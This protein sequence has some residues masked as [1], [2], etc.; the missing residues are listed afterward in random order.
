MSWRGELAKIPGLVP[1]VQLVKQSAAR[2]EEIV[3]PPPIV[4][5]AELTTNP[6]PGNP[7]RPTEPE[8]SARLPLTPDQYDRLEQTALEDQS[9]PALMA[10]RPATFQL[11]G[12][13]AHISSMRE[14]QRYVDHNFEP[15]LPA[16]FQAGATFPPI[17]YVNRFTQDESDLLNAV[18]EQVSI[19]TRQQFGRGIRPIGNLL[20]QT[21][22][23]RVMHHLAHT[24]AQPRLSVFE[25]GPG[26]GYLG[27]MLASTGHQYMSYDVTQA[28]YLWQSFL[29]DALAGDEFVELATAPGAEAAR[30]AHMPWWQYSKL[31]HNCP[32]RA[33]VVYSNSNLGEMTDLA[34]RH[35]LQ[36]SRDMLAGSDIGLFVYFSTGMTAQN[37]RETIVATLGEFGFQRI[38]EHPFNAFVVGTRNAARIAGAFAGGIPFYNPSGRGGAL[39]AN[40]VMALKRD[41]APL[42]VALAEWRFGWRPP[43]VD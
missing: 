30:V 5:A 25:V 21:G 40:A 3:P 29:L 18:R 33:D 13:P 27:A 23:F 6:L 24:F 26:M 36:I 12:Y 28:L 7:R 14:L 11:H 35:V 38:M 43:Y 10:F 15:E 4:A 41:E 20:V 19:A 22:P 31:V 34:L 1:L 2:K 39:A 37:S 32:V 42:D 16:F 8:R 17:G 9:I